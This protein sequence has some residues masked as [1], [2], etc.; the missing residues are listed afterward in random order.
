M[1]S[2]L[3]ECNLS[4]TSESSGSDEFAQVINSL[5]NSVSVLR[6]TVEEVSNNS[7]VLAESNAHIDEMIQDIFAQIN[8]SADSIENISASMEE[9]SAALL[10]LNATSEYVI[11]NT[12]HSVDAASEGLV[13]AQN[14]E[15]HSSKTYEKAMNSKNNIINLY[16]A[17]SENLKE[18]IEKVKTID[19][20]THMSNL[21]LNIAE[22]TSLL[23][24]NAAI[25][26]A[27]AGEQGKGFAVVAEEVKKLAEECSSAVNSIQADLGDVLS[28]VSDLTK[29][30][31]ELLTIFDTDILKD[32]DALI[33][34]SAEYK[35]SGHSVKEMVAK[36]TEASN[37][38]FKSITE[39]TNTISTLSDVVSTVADSSAHLSE[40]MSDINIKG[41]VISKTSNEGSEIVTKLSDSVSKFKL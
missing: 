19:N 21:I 22:Q 32:Y 36:F 24:L 38:T 14:I 27:R 25:E 29:F 9:S 6:N 11:D 28:A 18:S 41:S 3:S 10:E 8:E 30:S 7:N 17:C 39:M 13:L 33:A 2:E 5:N 26:A 4:Y 1:S 12:K 23:S 40:N 20:I 15:E 31:S 34:I 16:N 35:N 37:F